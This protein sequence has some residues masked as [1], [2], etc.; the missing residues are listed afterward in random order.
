MAENGNSIEVW[1]TVRGF[2]SYEVSS[3]GRVRSVDRISSRNGS[4]ALIHGAELKQRKDPRGYLRVTLYAGA[5]D[6]CKHMSVHRLVADTFIP[7]PNGLACVNHKDEDKLN[8]RAENL[9]WCTHKY[10][11][12]YGTAIARRVQHQDWKSI[13]EKQSTPVNQYDLNGNLIRTWESM[14]ECER[15]AGFKIVGISKCCSGKLK[16]YRGYKWKKAV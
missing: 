1:K 2:P 16:T 3:Y 12:N 15:E 4:S 5:R 7:N 13:A 8:N 14:S 9:E 10:N 6:N 11:S